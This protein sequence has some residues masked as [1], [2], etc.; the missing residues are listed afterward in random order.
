MGNLYGWG[1]N[2]DGSQ[3]AC[4]SPCEQKSWCHKNIYIVHTIFHY[5]Y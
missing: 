5:K 3:E 4:A 1:E 2:N